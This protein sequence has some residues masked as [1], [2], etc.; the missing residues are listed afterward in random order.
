MK[1]KK[2]ICPNCSF[3]YLD[4]IGDCE[5]EDY[6]LSCSK[7]NY[8]SDYLEKETSKFKFD[9]NEGTFK[10]ELKMDNLT[11]KNILITFVNDNE[12]IIRDLE[13]ELYFIEAEC[14]ADEKENA[15]ESIY[16]ELDFRNDLIKD[17]KYILKDIN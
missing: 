11:L 17:A 16:A 9:I 4:R 1:I 14:D 3:K 13:K 12:K 5:E 15:K 8:T 6:F 2:Y 7:C 10:G